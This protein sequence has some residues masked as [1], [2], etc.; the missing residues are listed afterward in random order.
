MVKLF[1]GCIAVKEFQFMICETKQGEKPYMCTVCGRQFHRSDYLKLHSYSHTDERPFSCQI[2]GK[3]FK[4]NYSLKLHL[5]NHN[6]SHA[7]FDF[8]TGDCG[9]DDEAHDHNDH[10]EHDPLSKSIL[11]L[12]YEEINGESILDL[13]AATAEA[14]ATDTTNINEKSLD[15]EQEQEGEE[16]NMISA[17]EDN[18]TRNQISSFFIEGI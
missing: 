2:C 14:S 3:G 4:M 8:G 17:Q 9:D 6:N 13:E 12:A 11:N 18:Q 1:L 15:E 16:A 5:K 10:H 7:G